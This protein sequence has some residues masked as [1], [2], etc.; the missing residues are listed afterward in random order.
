MEMKDKTRALG[1]ETGLTQLDNM[2]GGFQNSDLI[3]IGAGPS[4]GKTS[5]A[6]SMLQNITLENKMST[7]FF[8][9][10]MSGDLIRR[11]LL[12]QTARVSETE[13]R[14]GNLTMEENKK[15]Q[16]AT[17]AWKS[18]PLYIVDTPNMKLSDICS[19]SRKM[20][21][22]NDVRIIFIDHLALITLDNESNM[23]MSDLKATISKSLKNLACELNIPL[24]ALCQMPRAVDGEEPSLSQL[25]RYCSIGNDADV[26]MFIHEEMKKQRRKVI[27]AKQRDGRTGVV[28][29]RFIPSYSKFERE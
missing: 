22:Q 17:V 11:R 21:S 23:D 15:L 14:K 10:E 5:F 9:L 13:Y 16:N 26:I 28:P 18:A 8:N 2:I 4:M 25:Q 12:P 19:M 29:V 3:F 27:V 24:V 1:I 7:V 20:K 6:L